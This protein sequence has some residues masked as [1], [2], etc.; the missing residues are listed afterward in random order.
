MVGRASRIRRVGI[1]TASRSLPTRA[2]FNN[3]TSSTLP[4][5]ASLPGLEWVTAQGIETLAA[6]NRRLCLR[7]IEIVDRY[8]LTLASP[9]DDAERGGSVMIAM[10]SASAADAMRRQLLAVGFNCDARSERLRWSPGAVTTMEALDI[11]DRAL[12]AIG[13]ESLARSA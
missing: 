13:V 10:P 12:G 3:G 2:E 5:F 1:S 9:R 7:L 11:F 8:G 6:H 4:Y